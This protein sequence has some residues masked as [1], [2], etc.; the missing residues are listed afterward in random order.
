[1]PQSFVPLTT[2]RPTGRRGDGPPV[3]EFIRSPAAPP[4][5]VLRFPADERPEAHQPPE[6]AHVHDFLVLAYF[7]R[8][9]GTLRLGAREGPLNTGEAFVMGRGE[10]ARLSSHDPGHPAAGW[11]V[12]FP[13][14]LIA[15]EP[16]GGS[17][18]W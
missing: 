5:S 13:P 14:E 16:R 1:M 9:A 4:V 3:S 18:G 15:A 17:L 6:H 11:C 10:V 7:E 2:T 8:G 12:F